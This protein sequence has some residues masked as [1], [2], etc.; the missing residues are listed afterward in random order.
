MTEHEMMAE[1]RAL[2]HEIAT[3]DNRATNLPVYQVREELYLFA[4]DD[5]DADGWLQVADGDE[6]GAWGFSS[7]EPEAEPGCKVKPVWVV[8]RVAQ[9]FLTEKSAQRYLEEN[10]HNLTRPHVY[11]ES[12]YR[13]REVDLLRR[14]LAGLAR[15]SDSVDA[16]PEWVP[17]ESS[18]FDAVRWTR[19]SEGAD[20]E[21][22]VRFK[23]GVAWA[24]AAVPESLWVQLQAADSKGSF[25]ARNIKPRFEGRKLGAEVGS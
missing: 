10:K 21:L 6:P 12:G 13:N 5:A 2:G 3:Q 11:V 20:G 9:S 24:Y 4:P 25:F 19:S 7:V 18:N 22:Q 16:G 1:L 17:V 8:L 14:Y 15:P 23:S